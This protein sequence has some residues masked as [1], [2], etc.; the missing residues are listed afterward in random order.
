MLL[1]VYELI[2]SKLGTTADT[3]ELYIFMLVYDHDLIQGH[4]DARK[5]SVCTINIKPPSGFGRNLV[6]RWDLLV[7]LRESRLGSFEGK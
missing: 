6:C 4:M 1:D 5:Q 3:T 2:W 7:W